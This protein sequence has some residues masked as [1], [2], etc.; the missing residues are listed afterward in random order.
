MM[1]A[2]IRKSVRSPPSSLL[3]H[4]L[5]QRVYARLADVHH[6]Q[7]R[8]VGLGTGAR[9]CQHI[10]APPFAASDQSRLGGYTLR[11]LA[12]STSKMDS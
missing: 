2:Q 1:E 4:R 11:I 12:V 7:P 3:P 10:D 6:P 8:G 9:Y 5:C